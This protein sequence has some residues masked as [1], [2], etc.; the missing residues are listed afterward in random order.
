MKNKKPKKIS[1]L[2]KIKEARAY[3]EDSTHTPEEKIK[4][5]E[6]ILGNKTPSN[7]PVKW[8]QVKLKNIADGLMLWFEEAEENNYLITYFIKYHGIRPA[9]I[10]ILKKKSTYLTK[11]ISEFKLCSFDRLMSLEHF[12]KTKTSVT[13]K[14]KGGE[15]ESVTDT[16]MT[17][18][19]SRA[20]QHTLACE[21]EAFIPI[22][23]RS[24]IPQDHIFKNHW[25][26][27]SKTEQKYHII[28]SDAVKKEREQEEQKNRS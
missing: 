24:A 26:K 9:M 22:N 8:T 18:T 20:I 3:I 1:S 16:V 25:D 23:Q 11:V 13:K 27:L 10:S 21:N 28:N 6:I 12:P 2:Q 19:N 4:H 7:R 5:L 14:D 17:S 15:I